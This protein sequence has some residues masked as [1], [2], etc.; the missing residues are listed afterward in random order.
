MNRA[1]RRALARGVAP[2]LCGICG[3]NLTK[4]IDVDRHIARHAEQSTGLPA[5]VLRPVVRRLDR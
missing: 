1:E 5:R 2:R 4:V 3:A